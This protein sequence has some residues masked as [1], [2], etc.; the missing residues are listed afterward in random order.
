MLRIYWANQLVKFVLRFRSG[1]GQPQAGRIQKSEGKKSS[2]GMG[3]ICMG[4]PSFPLAGEV[5]TRDWAALMQPGLKDSEL[6]D[7]LVTMA[8]TP[9]FLTLLTLCSGD[10]L[11]KAKEIMGDT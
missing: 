8:W 5:D 9:L 4:G 3:V 10:W 2:G 7:N 6:C 11:C 1:F